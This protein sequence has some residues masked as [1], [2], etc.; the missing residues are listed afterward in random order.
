MAEYDDDGA[1]GHVALGR[2][3][4]ADMG[5]VVPTTDHKLGQMYCDY[6]TKE[7]DTDSV[8]GAIHRH[9][10]FNVNT[11]SDFIAQY[12]TRQEYRF[13]GGL[14]DPSSD[15]SSV[16]ALSRLCLSLPYIV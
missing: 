3:F 6:I 10:D 2:S 14:P 8:I 5:A 12:T 7:A 13:A 11:A 1:Y 4:A 16:D 15:V 9:S